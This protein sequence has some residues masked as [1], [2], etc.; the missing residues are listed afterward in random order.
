MAGVFFGAE[1][2]TIVSSERRA[3]S[4]R[5]KSNDGTGNAILRFH[6]GPTIEHGSMISGFCVYNDAAM[7]LDPDVSLPIW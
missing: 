4:T 1:T 2:K 7:Y 6:L 5:R 3:P